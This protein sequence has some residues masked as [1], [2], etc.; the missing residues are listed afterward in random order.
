MNIVQKRGSLRADAH[1]RILDTDTTVVNP[2]L[3]YDDSQ[4]LC[5]GHCAY[6]V[7]SVLQCQFVFVESYCICEGM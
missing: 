1:E 6:A 3:V 2:L 5:F 4:K 7:W